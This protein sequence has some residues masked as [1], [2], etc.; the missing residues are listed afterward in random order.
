M[1][2]PREETA[3]IDYVLPDIERAISGYIEQKKTLVFVLLYS[4]LSHNRQLSL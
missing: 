4:Q 2:W 3:F 1:N